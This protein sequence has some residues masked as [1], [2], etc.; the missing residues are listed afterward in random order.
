[1]VRRNS[2]FF[3]FV[4]EI[5]YAKPKRGKTAQGVWKDIVNVAD[6][7]QTLRMEKCL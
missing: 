1:M 6:Y 4:T 5:K 7:T 2:F 3:F